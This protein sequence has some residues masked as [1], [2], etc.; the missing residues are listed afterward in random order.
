MTRKAS[1]RRKGAAETERGAQEADETEEAQEGTARV[2]GRTGQDSESW[3]VVSVY[4]TRMAWTKFILSSSIS[5]IAVHA[6]LYNAPL[7]FPKGIDVVEGSVV[8]AV[9]PPGLLALGYVLAA[10][11]STLDCWW[12]RHSDWS[13]KGHHFLVVIVL[14]VAVTSTETLRTLA[15]YA[16]V[17]EI[18]SPFY[19]LLKLRFRPDLMRVCAVGLNITVRAPFAIWC[20]CIVTKGLIAKADGNDST[21]QVA[22]GTSIVFGIVPI[23]LCCIDVVWTRAMVRTLMRRRQSSQQVAVET[24]TAAEDDTLTCDRAAASGSLLQLDIEAPEPPAVPPDV[25]P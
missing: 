1:R 23:I 11:L 4:D 25:E 8:G 19:Q 10:L 6:L 7:S 17:M 2:Q 16:F 21:N 20:A 18:V 22:V 3:R 24:P 12:H 5:A 14:V 15:L 9:Y 13:T